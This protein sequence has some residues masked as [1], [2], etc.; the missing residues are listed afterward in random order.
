MGF[1]PTLLRT[2]TPAGNASCFRTPHG[3]IHVVSVGGAAQADSPS[4]S[5][6]I[7]FGLDFRVTSHMRWIAVTPMNV[8]EQKVE[9]RHFTPTRGQP[10]T[11]LTPETLV[12]VWANAAG[13]LAAFENTA[14]VN[15]VGWGNIEERIASLPTGYTRRIWEVYEMLFG[16]YNGFLAAALDLWP[17]VVNNIDPQS[18]SRSFARLLDPLV[19][20]GLFLDLQYTRDLYS[21]ACEIWHHQHGAHKAPSIDISAVHA[22]G[23]REAFDQGVRIWDVP[24]L[25]A[26]AHA[27]RVRLMAGQYPE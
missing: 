18:T 4:A 19:A 10:I 21:M 3:E 6:A 1:G 25:R 14:V 27:E 8:P 12:S 11:G 13:G 26:A 2:G 9:T 7:R 24:H 5:A 22:R 15:L 17:D 23:L 20:T 16:Q